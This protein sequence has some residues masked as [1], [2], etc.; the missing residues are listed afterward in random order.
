MSDDGRD[1]EMSDEFDEF[2]R[3]V[4]QSRAGSVAHSI[5][6]L[7]DTDPRDVEAH[8]VMAALDD[9]ARSI[10]ADIEPQVLRA[11]LEYALSYMLDVGADA[12]F[13]RGMGREFVRLVEQ[14]IDVLHRKGENTSGLLLELSR[15]HRQRSTIGAVRLRTLE[16]ALDLA[17]S[18]VEHMD[19]MLAMAQ[20]ENDQSN[21]PA[22]RQ[23]LEQCQTLAATDAELTRLYSSVFLSRMGWSYFYSDTERAGQCYARAIEAGR[24]DLDVPQI[25]QAVAE[26]HHFRGRLL[27]QSGDLLGAADEYVTAQHMSGTGLSGSAYFHLRLGELLLDVDN[28][29]HARFHLDRSD[30]A[31]DLTRDDSDGRALLAAGWARYFIKEG[32]IAAAEEMIERGLARARRDGLWRPQLILLQQSVFQRLAR[33]W[34]I[35]AAGALFRALTLF[36]LHAPRDI[37]NFPAS[38]RQAFTLGMRSMKGR[39]NKIHL[40]SETTLQCPCQDHR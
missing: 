10:E 33:G 22:V 12:G 29:E 15:F 24:D 28:L 40:P 34:R 30:K 3:Q 2:L 18:P 37:R 11:L 21:F 27:A 39:S 13:D 4:R 1:E 38:I 7:L 20:F 8:R 19:A 31:F 5:D 14:L 32:D 16:R 23:W 26:A 25:R 17:A 6:R 9:L 36:F 35:G